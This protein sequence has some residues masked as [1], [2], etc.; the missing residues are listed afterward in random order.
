MHVRVWKFRPPPGR[1]EAFADIYGPQ[2]RWAELFKKKRGYLG[3]SLL[4]PSQ[5]GDWW[6][7]IDRWQSIQD[8]E[9][10]GRDFGDEYLA[11]DAGLEGIAGDEAFVGAF[12][13]D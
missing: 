1:E 5:A 11:L 9:A 6:M 7:T 8:F 3:T 10:F 4:R 12:E 13:E 2:G